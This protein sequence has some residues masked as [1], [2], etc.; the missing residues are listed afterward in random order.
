MCADVRTLIYDIKIAGL[1]N[2]GLHVTEMVDILAG[3]MY[4]A[5]SHI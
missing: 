5:L 2:I 3:F 4:W 1:R